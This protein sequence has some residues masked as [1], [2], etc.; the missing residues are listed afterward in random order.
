[1]SREKGW[2][3]ITDVDAIV[4][5]WQEMEYLQC[6]PDFDFCLAPA[7]KALRKASFSDLIQLLST[8][9]HDCAA[10]ILNG[11]GCVPSPGIV[12]GQTRDNDWSCSSPTF[13]KQTEIPNELIS[14]YPLPTPTPLKS[15][16]ENTLD[17]QTKLQAITSKLGSIHIASETGG[18]DFNYDHQF[19]H[20]ASNIRGCLKSFEG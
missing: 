13:Y 1:M 4:N 19:M 11:G 2:L 9:L 16:G 5:S 17:L 6:F 20:S 15:L 14:K 3:R 7:E 12:V 10:F 18:Y 8:D